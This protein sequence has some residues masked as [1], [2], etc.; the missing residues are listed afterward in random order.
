MA[1]NKTNKEL[2]L[3]ILENQRN[4]DERI[5]ELEKLAHPQGV[6]VDKELTAAL[7]RIAR[8]ETPAWKGQM[9]GGKTG[10]KIC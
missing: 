2:L 5:S 9:C 3:E 8:E 1:K 6:L 4:M 10:R 7:R